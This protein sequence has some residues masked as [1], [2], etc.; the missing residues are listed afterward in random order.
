MEIRD[1]A[2]GLEKDKPPDI[3]MGKE[4]NSEKKHKRP[5]NTGKHGQH[6]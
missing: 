2:N 1:L 4:D 6:H 3:K 5:L